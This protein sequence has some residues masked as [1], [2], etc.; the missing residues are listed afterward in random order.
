MEDKQVWKVVYVSS[1]QEKKVA[2]RLEKEGIQS[3]LPLYK[4]LSQW[5]D[6]RKWVE[7]PLFNGYLFVRPTLLNRDKVMQSHGVVAFVRHNNGDAIVQDE[8]IEIMKNVMTSGYTLET[9]NTPEDFEVGERVTVSEGPLKGHKVDILRQNNQEN[10]L[11]S[12]DTL[13]QSIKIELP[14]HAFEKDK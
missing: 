12:F 11:V 2:L 1:R 9:I 5:S 6:R 13:G 10:F 7:V 3:F 4:K 14:F 8:E